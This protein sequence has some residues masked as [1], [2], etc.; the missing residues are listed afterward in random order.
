MGDYTEPQP[1][2]LG[3][4]KYNSLEFESK[5]SP[6]SFPLL[7]D[8]IIKNETANRQ[9]KIALDIGSPGESRKLYDLCEQHNVMLS[10]TFYAVW[11]LV[12]GRYL[13]IENV[14]FIAVKSARNIYSIGVCETD[15][16]DTKTVSQVLKEA[17]ENLKRSFLTYSSVSWPEFKQANAVEGRPTFNSI[18]AVHEADSEMTSVMKTEEHREDEYIGINVNVLPER[19]QADLS[20]PTS[21]LTHAQAENVASTYCQVLLEVTQNLQKK[22]KAINFMSQQHMNQI[23]NWNQKTP[24]VVLD[25]VYN[26]FEARAKASPDSQAIYA[27]DGSLTYR[28]LAETSSR[29]AHHLVNLGVGPE[30]VVPLC[31]EKSKWAI[32]T[33]L[34]VAKAGGAIVNLD[35]KQPMERLTGIVSQVNATMILT[36]QKHKNLWEDQLRVFAV[37]DE[38]ISKLSKSHE[39]SNVKI[40]PTTM[41]YVIFTSGSTGTPKGC[42]IEHSSFLTAA[43]RHAEVSRMDS[44]SRVLQMAPYTFDTSM[45]EIFTTLTTG[46]CICSCGDELAQKGI[47]NVINSMQITWT[48]MTPS[49]VRVLDPAEVP[50]LKTLALGGEALGR[51][52][53][54]TWA[55]KLQLVNGYGPTECSV[56]ATIHGQVSLDSDPAN[57]GRGEGAVCWIVDANDHNRLVPIGAIGELVIQGPIVARGYLNNEAKTTEVFLDEAPTFEKDR[58]SKSQKFRLYKTGDLVR[59]NSDG[60]I[61][62][63]GRKDKQVKLRGQ[64]LELGEIEHHLSADNSVRNALVV[65]PTQGLCSQRLVAVL[66]LHSFQSRSTNDAEVNLVPEEH[67]K[68]SRQLVSGI[69]DRLSK[70]VPAYMIPTAWLVLDSIPLM[71]SGKINGVVMKRWIQGMSEDVYNEVADVAVETHDLASATEMEAALQA[72]WSH[73]LKIPVARVGLNR[74]F[75]GLGGDSITAMRVRSRCQDQNIEVSVQDIIQSKGVSDLAAISVI[76]KL[77]PATESS[78][79]IEVSSSQQTEGLVTGLF[80]K[81][82]LSSIDDVEDVYECSPM[83]EGILLSQV[84]LPGTYAIR[85]VLHVL[86]KHHASTTRER[87]EVAWQRVVDRHPSLR[88]V[89]VEGAADSAE[90]KLFHQVVLKHHTTAIPYVKYGG[91]ENTSDIS[92]FL[93]AQPSPHYKR[94][95]PQHQL[96]ICQS[97]GS[98]TYILVDISH[99]LIDGGSTGIL[100]DDLALAFDGLLASASGPLYSNYIRYLQTQPEIE[101]E[102]FWSTYLSGIQ[103][104]IVPMYNGAGTTVKKI[105]SVKVDFNDAPELLKFSENHGVTIANI[106]QTAWGLVLRLYTGSDDVC[107]GYVASGRDVRIQGIED[108]VGAFI[109]MLVC[110]LT[111]DERVDS[112]DLVKRMQ[113]DYFA[114][115]PHQ[116]CSLAKIQHALNM[117]GMPLFNTILSL[118]RTVSQ[119]PNR[120]SLSF[121]PVEEDDPTDFDIAVSINVGADDLDISLGYWTSLMSDGDAANIAS[122]F[123][124]AI[125]SV[126]QQA[127]HRVANL[128]LFTERDRRQIW[129]W[130]K[131]EVVGI[132]SCVHEYFHEQVLKQPEAQAVCS[133]DG[134]FTYRELD[135][136]S[137]RLAYYLAELGVGPE[138]LVPHCFDKSKWAAVTMMAIMKSG[139]GGVGLSSA[140]PVPRL[141]SIIEGCKANVI[142]VAPQHAELLKGLAEHIVVVDPSFLEH[143]PSIPSGKSLPKASPT[144][145]AFVSFT[146]GSTG[147]PKGIVIE[148][149]S[150]ITSIQ[151][152]GSEWN[153]GPGSRVIQFSA[154]AFDASISDT[155]TTLVRGGTVCIPSD[156]DRLNNLAGA[157]SKMNVNWAFLTPRVLG[158][159]SP[160]TVPQLKTVV[161][162]GEAISREDIAPWTDALDLRIVYGPTEC[163]I[164]S[165]GTEPVTATSDPACLGRAVGTRV[166]VTDPGNSDKLVPVGCI[167][168]L[169]IEG[170]LVTRGYLNDPEKTQVAFFEDPTWVPKGPAEAPRRF[171]KTSDLV[172]YYPDGQLQFIGRRDTQIKIRGQRVE[173]GEIE[174]AIMQNLP[175]VAHVSVDS[176]VFPPHRQT[177]VAFLYMKDSPSQSTPGELALPL[178]LESVGELRDLEKTLTDC[179]PSYMVPSMFVPIS[180]IPLTISGKVDRIQLRAAALHFSPEQLEMFSLTGQEKAAPTTETETKLQAL[181]AQILQKDTSSIGTND[182]FFRLGGDSVGAMKLVTAAR[183]S[184][185]LLA[186]ADIF[187]Y[188]ELSRMAEQV[189]IIDDDNS[190]LVSSQPFGLLNRTIQT[191]ELLQEAAAQCSIETDSIQDIYPCTPLQEGVF[192]LST[193]QPGAYIARTAFHLPNDL[194]ME[195]FQKAWQIL[196]DTHAILRTRIVLFNSVS[197]QVVLDPSAASIQW[198]EKKSSDGLLDSDKGVRIVHGDPLAHYEIVHGEGQSSFIWTAHHAIYDGWTVPLL[199]EQLEGVYHSGYA[200]TE[201]PYSRFIQYLHDSDT[202][203]SDTFWRSQLSGETPASYP[204]LPSAAYQPRP[205]RVW[206]QS[207]NI[208]AKIGSDITMAIILRAAWALVVARY[209]DSNDIVYGLTL[210]GRDAPVKDVQQTLGPTITTVPIKVSLDEQHT[211]EEFLKEI[212]RQSIDMKPYEHTG[213]QNIRRVS[214]EAGPASD[215]KNLFVVQPKSLDSQT[216]LGLEPIPVD[217][218]QFDTYALVIECALGAGTVDIEARYDSGILSD[219]QMETLLHQY[220]HVIQQVNNQSAVTK[221]GDVELLSEQDKKKILQWNAVAPTTDNECVHELITR[222]VTM[223]PDIM[224]VES[225]DGN[226]TYQQLDTLSSRLACYLSTTLGINAESLVPMCFDKSVWTVV[227]MLSVVKAGGACVMLNPEH[228]VTRLAALLEDT[229]SHII[230]SSPEREG[231]FATLPRPTFAISASF[232]QHLP[233]VSVADL[234]LLHVVPSNPAVIIFT[235]GST[236]KPKGI[237][238]QHNSLCTV[239]TQHGDG[240]GFGG[241]GSRVLQFAN[242]TFDVSVGEIFVTLMRGGTI[243]IATEYDRINNLAWVINSMKITWT[244]MT[245]TVA[246][247]LDPK[248]VPNLKTLVLGGEAVSQSLV[249][250]WSKHVTMI[251]SYGPAE[252]TIWTSHALPG[253]TVAPSNIGWG[254]GCRLWIVESSDHNR[255]SPVGC[256]GELL[257]EGPNVARGYMNEPEKTKAAF[258]ENPSWMP[259]DSSKSYRFYKSGDLV[260]YNADGSLTIAGRKDTQVKF[261]GQRIELGEIEFHLRARAE[262]EAGMVTLPKVGLCKAK[263][264]GVVA[265]AEFEPLALE[266]NAVGLIPKDSQRKSQEIVA[267]IQD[268]MSKLLPPYMVPSVWVVLD[269]IPLTASRKINRVPI[270]RWI[271]DVSEETY[272]EIVNATAV[273]EDMPTTAIE[274]Q[275][276]GVWSQILDIP[277]DHIG[278]NR[279]FLS[280][281]GD[282]I[283]AMQVVSRCRTLKVELNVHDVLQSKSLSEVALRATSASKTAISK[284]ESF[285]NAFELSPIQ[286]LY[287]DEIVRPSVPGSKEHHYNQSVLLRLARPV[288]EQDVLTAFQTLVSKNSM[289]RAR[290]IE[291]EEGKWMQ[292]VERGAENSYSL[293]THEF[294][295]RKDI[296]EIIES[297]QTSINIREGP[298]FVIDLFNMAD[299]KQHLSMIAHH[300][301]IDVVSWYVIVQELE[302]LLEGK[303][304]S[305]EPTL[306][307]QTWVKMQAEYAKDLSPKSVL[308]CNVPTADL[309]YWGLN[310]LPVWKDVEEVTF[311][312]DEKITSSLLGVANTALHTEPLDIIISALQHAFVQTFTDRGVPAIFT[313]GHGREPWN[314]SIDLSGTVGWFTTLLPI[315]VPITKDDDTKAVVRVTKDTRRRVSDNGFSYFSCRSFNAEGATAF[316]SHKNIEI[317]LNYLGRNQQLERESALLRQEPLSDGEVINNIGDSLGRLAVFDVSAVITQGCFQM[318]FLFN[319][320]THHQEKIQDWVRRCEQLLKATV[321][322][323]ESSPVEYTLSDFPLISTNY[324]GLSNLFESTLPKIGVLSSD[325][326][327]LY[328]CAPIQEGIILSQAREPGTYEVRQCFEVASRTQSTPID[329]NRLQVAW[330][331]V[332]NRHAALRTIFI[333]TITQNGVYDQLVLR[334][335]T[336]DVKRLKYEGSDV[337]SFIESQLP[338]DYSQPRPHHRL[339]IC[340]AMG[341]VY[342]QLEVSHS[343]TDGTSM[344]LI[345]RDL[346]AAYES[347]LPTGSSALYK[348]YIAYLQQLSEPLSLN[349]W[350]DYLADL[351]PCHF[352]CLTGDS[353]TSKPSLSKSIT[354][355]LDGAS[356]LQRFCEAHEITIGN[357]FQAAWG[358]IL[359]SYTGSDEVCFGYMASGRDIPLKDISDAIGPYI[360]L[361][362]CKLNLEGNN[363]VGQV[364][365][366]LQDDYLNCLPHQH[367]SLAKIQHELENSGES[368]FNT[369][370]SIQRLPTGVPEQEISFEVVDQADPTEYDVD[371]NITIGDKSVEIHMTY[372][373]AYLQEDQAASLIHKFSSVL[374]YISSDFEQPL[375]SLHMFGEYDHD[376]ISKLNCSIPQG[377]EECVHS[378]VEQQVQLRPNAE[379]ISWSNGDSSMTY[380]ELDNQANLLKERLCTLGVGS[381]VVVPLCCDQ[382]SLAIVAMLAVLKA[383]GAYCM[384][385]PQHTSEHLQAVTR[386]LAS[387]VVICSPQY[388]EKFNFADI[389]VI[390]LDHQILEQTRAAVES[391]LV[392]I[393]PGN[394]AIVVLDSESTEKVDKVVIEHRSISTAAVMHGSSVNLGPEARVLQFATYASMSSV[395]EIVFTLCNG[396][397]VCIP[398]H[399]NAGD[400]G[401]TIR[402][403]NV[404]WAVLTSTIA[405][406]VRPIDVPTLKTLAVMGDESIPNVLRVWKDVQLVKIYGHAETSIWASSAQEAGGDK[407]SASDIGRAIASRTWIVESANHKLLAPVGCVGE[408]LIEGPIVSRGYLNNAEKTNQIFLEKPP[409]LGEELRS[410]MKARSERLYKTGKLARYTDNGSISLLEHPNDQSKL[411]GRSVDF[412]KVEDQVQLLISDSHQAAVEIVELKVRRRSQALAVFVFEAGQMTRNSHLDQLL[413]PMTESLETELNKL[414]ADLDKSLPKCSIPTLFIPLRH[415]PL[416]I[417]DN[418]DRMTLRKVGSLLNQDLINQYSLLRTESQKYWSSNEKI[419]RDLWAET[420]RTPASTIAASDSFFALGGDSIGAMRLVNAAR[421]QGLSLTIAAVFQQPTLSKMAKELELLSINDEPLL[422]FS[423]IEHKASTRDIV[424][425]ATNQCGI[426]EDLVEDIYPCT[427]L[428]EGLMAI[429]VRTASAYVIQEVFSIPDTLDVALFQKAWESVVNSSTILRTRIISTPSG[430]YQVVLKQGISWE[431]DESLEQY[432][433][434][435]QDVPIIYGGPLARYAVV[436][437]AS[438]KY[439][440]WT[441]HH[442]IYDGLTLPMIATRVSAIYRDE[443][444]LPEVPYGRFVQYLE[445]GDCDSAAAFWTAQFS[446]PSSAFPQL[447][448]ATYQP[449]ADQLQFRSVSVQRAGSDITLSTVL[450]AAWGV[451]LGVVSE[452]DAVTFGITVSGRNAPIPGVTQIMG[453]TISTVPIRLNV[454]QEQSPLEYL[455]KVQQQAVDMIPF[456]HTGLQN[457]RNFSNEA[458]D[459]TDIRNLLLI[460]P[461]SMPI[462]GSDFLGLT[463]IELEAEE[464]DPY[465]LVVECSISHD[466]VDIKAQYDGGILSMQEVQKMLR[467]FEH[468]I[469]VLNDIKETA[470]S[471]EFGTLE[472][473]DSISPEDLEQ[474]TQWNSRR[475]EA[476]ES[477]VHSLFEE[478]ALLRPDAQAVCSFDGNFTYKQLNQ[479]ADKLA[480]HLVGLGVE[481]ERKVALCFAKSSST[482]I[483]MLAVMKS[484]GVCAMLSPDHPS[485]RIKALVAD[486]EAT[487][488]LCDPASVKLLSKV[489]PSTGIVS[490]DERSLDLLPAIS[491]PVSAT[492]L[493]SNAVFIMHTSGSTGK[494]K[495]II[496]EH[497]SIATGLLAHGKEMGIGPDTRT[498]Q[499]AAYTFDVCLEE[500]VT[501]LM[502][503]GCVCV[504]SESERMNDIAGAMRKFQVTWT[505]LTPTVASLLVPSSIPSLKVLALSGES[506]TKEVVNIWADHVQIINTYGPSECSV[507][508]TCNTATSKLRDPSNIGRGF[509]CT[510]WIVDPNNIDR[511]APVGAIGELLVE[512]PIVARGYL[513]EPEKTAAAFITNPAWAES[514]HGETVRLYRTGD[515]VKYNPDGS[516]KFIGRKDTQVKLHGQRIEMG[517]IEHQIKIA[518]QESSQQVAVEVITPECRGNLKILAAF[519]CA[520]ESSNGDIDN[521]TLPFSK[522]F[523]KR[524]L[525]LQSMLFNA[526][527]KHMVPSL[528]IPVGHM[529]LSTS[530]KLD[531]KTIR[532]VAN[533]FSLQQ[534]A[535]YS[536]VNAEK[537]APSTET[538]KILHKL[539]AQVLHTPD[540]GIEDNFFLLGGDSIGAMKVVAAAS[541]ANISLTVADMLREPTLNKMAQQIDSAARSQV[542]EDVPPEPFALLE[543][544]EVGSLRQEAAKQCGVHQDLIEDIYKC[545]P[546]QEGLMAIT[547][548]EEDAYISQTVYRLPLTIDL[549][550]YQAAW[551]TIAQL[552]SILRT[553]II[554]TSSSQSLQVVVKENLV[555]RS[556]SVLAEYLKTDTL[557]PMSYGQPLMR[558]GLVSG[559]GIDPRL[560]FIYTAHHSVYDG[561]SEATLFEQVETIYKHGVSALSPV[562]PYKNFI[563]YLA[564]IDTQASDAFWNSQLSGGSPSAFPELPSTSY[565]A[566]PNRTQSHPFSVS[567]NNGL[568]FTIPTILKSAWSLLL[569]RYTNSDDV[570]FGHVLSGRTIPLRD[571]GNMVGPTIATVPIRVR[572]DRT[573]TI[574]QFLDGV[575]EQATQ[576]MP[577]EQA[578]LQHI[579]R[580]AP[581]LSANSDFKHLFYIQPSLEANGEDLN[582]ELIPT[583]NYAFDTY[584][585]LVECQISD[586]DVNFS[587]RYDDFV[588][589]TEQV[590]WMLRHLEETV[591]QLSQMPLNLNLDEVDMFGKSDLEQV[592]NWNGPA[593]KPLNTCVHELFRAQ[594]RVSPRATA[595]DAWDG[596]MTYEQL[597]SLASRLSC[598]LTTVGVGAN[599]KVALCFQKSC[600]AIVS[601]LAVM[602]AGGACV[603]LNPDHPVSRLTEI[604]KDV[605]ADHILSAPGH[606]ATLEGL[607]RYL[608]I[609]DATIASRLSTTVNDSLVSVDPRCAA[610]LVFTSGSTGKPKSVVIDHRA[611]C[612][613]IRDHSASLGLNPRS[614]VLQFAAYTF[615][616]SF[617]EIFSTL[618]HGGTVCV[619][620]EHDRM[621][622][623]SSAMNEMEVNWACL[624]PTVASLLRPADVPGLNTLALSGEC[625]TAGNLA[626]WAGKI[627]KLTNI[628]GPSEAS[629]WCS[630]LEELHF[631]TSPANI[632]KAVG[633]RLWVTE[634]NNVNRLAPIGCIGELLVEGPILAQGYLGDPVKTAAAFVEKPT[635]M[636][637]FGIL[638][639]QQRVY[640]TGDLVKYNRNGTLQYLGRN[641]TQIKFHGQRIEPREIEHHIKTH[642]P[643]TEVVVDAVTLNSEEKKTVLVAYFCD[644]DTTTQELDP[645]KIAQQPSKDAQGQFAQLQSALFKQLPAPMVPSL[646]VPLL[647]MPISSAGKLNRLLLSQMVKGLADEQLQ[648]YS[649]ADAEKRAPSTKMEIALVNLW[650][651]ALNIEPKTIGIDDS[652]FRLGGD[653]I[654]AM[655]LVSLARAANIS[656]SIADIFRHPT[657]VDAATVLAVNSPSTPTAVEEPTSALDVQEGDAF[658]EN[659]VSQKIGTDRSNISSVLRTTNFQDLAI[660]GSLT[661]SRWMLNYFYLDGTG[662]VDEERMRLSCLKLVQS[663]DILRTIFVL[664]KGS[665]WQVV[666]RNIEP[667]FIVKETDDITECTEEVY[668]QGKSCDLRLEEPFVQFTLV[669][670]QHGYAHRLIVRIS[671]AQ[672]DG[673]SLPRLWDCLRA[674]YADEKITTSPPFTNYLHKANLKQPKESFNHWRALLDGSS[675]TEFVARQ[676]PDLRSSSDVVTTLTSRIPH[677]PL[678]DHGITFA[679][680]IKSA[681][682]LVLAQ[683]AAR[684]DVVFGHTISGR[685]VDMDEVENIVGPCLNVVPVRVKFQSAWKVIDLLR[686]VQ[687]QQLTNV[688]FESLGFR[689]IIKNCTD[690]PQWSYFS[691]IV[692]HQNIDPDDPVTLGTDS[693]TPGFIGSD[694]DLV[695]ISILSMPVGDNVDV[696]LTASARTI[697]QEDS[698]NLL[699]LL[700]RTITELSSNVLADLSTPSELQ[701]QTPV[702]PVPAGSPLS[703]ASTRSLELLDEKTTLTLQIM[704]ENTWVKVL[705]PTT[706]VRFNSCFFQL[707]GDM[708]GMTQLALLFREQKYEVSLEDLV[709]YSTVDGM[710]QLLSTQHGTANG[711]QFGSSLLAL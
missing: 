177:L 420:L 50:G 82:N 193:T 469:H 404:N 210:S 409:W 519:V 260:R 675:M 165:M 389:E 206:K 556:G 209:A 590:T 14:T 415:L 532:E 324:R 117:S 642:L 60:T 24:E 49:L 648:L 659:V 419:L 427:P 593:V 515:L 237:I 181:F 700:C 190:E 540:I 504:P 528:Y 208:D 299:G 459:A 340:E 308:P 265:L 132:E 207:V 548:R 292:V 592:L 291:P 182:S 322:S 634:R 144:N 9:S 430:S 2:D 472:D 310:R 595:I 64:R 139:G 316:T 344:A 88:T 156:Q 241:V 618:I 23:W 541:K 410:P 706:E 549:E 264:V 407:I 69:R 497:R 379:A 278:A 600:W 174:H 431:S 267:R 272:H 257:I 198:Q 143:L 353:G 687:E 4:K 76:S 484:G 530:G 40:L 467:Q 376:K 129:D 44:S 463:P 522:L 557:L 342:L 660:T 137:D 694:L 435:D 114:A 86:S 391:T 380:L 625:P 56:A 464:F 635:W 160:Q 558:F 42:I 227:V 488:V 80:S 337:V 168:E 443:L 97:A 664:H 361:V 624:T 674:A 446:D 434:R 73:A 235:S 385:N 628:Y 670:Q 67:R 192:I 653:S 355:H 620:S 3:T 125:T 377:L 164:F 457:I 309:S 638:D 413:L 388:R 194:N 284:D 378:L 203:A 30:V 421:S 268:G 231:L 503:G 217:L 269:A 545:S 498:L 304:S 305:T 233:E 698:K 315:H 639:G 502:L 616:I 603:M 580:I 456:E 510:L 150:L 323:L 610:Y 155:F 263:L 134:D 525:T 306:P 596:S 47:A 258:I 357:L 512:G 195:Q 31:F 346:T 709:E 460:Q 29:L 630:C 672:Y 501:T 130:N 18:V 425:Q 647:A 690:W 234:E 676:K 521:L 493:P 482:I 327:D 699:D 621:N 373:D 100:L 95:E 542:T 429:S 63:I 654:V 172:R 128:D 22:L 204:R 683:L 228:P 601:M 205:D 371:F 471:T 611:I 273:V 71:T 250:R 280:L 392:Q 568:A 38:S 92:K 375:A 347:A 483:A 275:L 499:F 271:E 294:S 451:V 300:L 585:L 570:L 253:P 645:T 622:N 189:D 692:Q 374:E 476:V 351:S 418:L 341:K 433:I 15:L 286:R 562:T 79:R 338:V 118:Q 662:S 370:M 516:I 641:D 170:P 594:A 35:A 652:F 606:R 567:R 157:M 243:C 127:T 506:L 261:H 153:V 657:I 350:I 554:H 34:A 366:T 688:P 444:A 422:P 408:L 574:E 121:E 25:T 539:W 518:L 561:W 669:K 115:L 185:L 403:M 223:H 569:S 123:S 58:P 682:A 396:G 526:L 452:S 122:T 154:Y 216:V 229:N 232:I 538:E 277:E 608:L 201:A 262:V 701:S 517:E 598:H 12:L 236:G 238:V 70:H 578:G 147:K 169:I 54:T 448:N 587:V 255:L 673:I 359:R 490:I 283:T 175:D 449:K 21:L 466:K 563:R 480:H 43:A 627:T 615:D 586:N 535:S 27:H 319:R 619:I 303:P 582:L 591:H 186:V 440:I 226:L 458:K 381:E 302:E 96:T 251:D 332:V 437:D 20:Y 524:F 352:P 617:G 454:S 551:Q 426:S 693:Y 333:D 196:V 612:S 254:V 279:S 349:Y 136:V 534:L 411:N 686:Y 697:P 575:Q 140:H 339:T 475:P 384:L 631:D 397:T 104:T 553:R 531:R 514:R 19:F 436:G 685:N 183:E 239:A 26:R 668:H 281:G 48:F 87:L 679:T 393:S 536:L 680:V 329:A 135:D 105:R 163:T 288:R 133:W 667:K 414:K 450:R 416:T 141:Q 573:M 470:S 274:K 124:G 178:T 637:R 10:T 290:F 507:S 65:L 334:Q 550:R 61:N 649:L 77:S 220:E 55:D 710:I 439:F 477:C 287:F 354:I 53:V 331:L 704:V 245:P 41:L 684:S 301:I 230:L 405:N 424:A 599:S 295:E 94:S 399:E 445:N 62:F 108:A 330:Q 326:E 297:R 544:G 116:H 249:D 113:S 398:C 623:L 492:V 486:L 428:Q 184:G 689:E 533:K 244:F 387:K 485:E 247:L 565:E 406:L 386:D 36:S 447:P 508:T 173:L 678:N 527:P 564:N 547:A 523:E 461:A 72:I 142:L 348:D 356:K 658:L 494:P 491:E 176:V 103:P 441:A 98:E 646:F 390:A 84:K 677:I 52:D 589:S 537:Q 602:K 6:C 179:L 707:G 613:S 402:Q 543:D 546:L 221:I 474:I 643:S 438:E 66:S 28:E 655:K 298:L 711:V 552:Q 691:S 325:V 107:F 665:F 650:A 218:T 1:F 7:T 636:E 101:G 487:L 576:M 126:L 555:W 270:S 423:L 696:S 394:S 161:L 640:R 335:Y 383:G 382:T 462:T 57:I 110:R 345:I 614:R 317:C 219:N 112:V 214:N 109:N 212:Q 363:T 99:A 583:E 285:G 188:P 191:E 240:L 468:T 358:L 256:V 8:G 320:N 33:M 158:T 401:K 368:L 119:D 202:D 45:L 509:G 211:V 93:K 224:A 365:K 651:R 166:W 51:I 364:L 479:V 495:G 215:F 312:L 307:F 197:Y 671:H 478:Q 604:I 131:E 343:L 372:A 159:L 318:S 465:P 432:L 187:R 400:V 13:G 626:T 369:I 32:V 520:N 138:I 16:T 91:S 661:Q 242:Y 246:A 225:W 705:P 81:L 632:G 222:Q 500:I 629:I 412:G 282:S 566:R 289:L 336:A 120:T 152:H 481:P 11:A 362:V 417:S 162:G 111:V 513:K 248:E 605:A 68:Q 146:S 314:S 78:P 644:K 39:T 453:P 199:F 59:N 106:L 321:E 597:E 360:N 581:E 703:E 5:L 367:T 584:S 145:A 708:V 559:N 75:I 505:E 266:G 74:S 395:A 102:K 200:P 46:A 252:C 663:F 311:T 633:C 151:A 259:K 577:F 572:L 167:G 328:P 609:V 702:I 313:E 681:W 579:R 455:K 276:A 148:H 213:I 695:D 511:L 529:P 83:Q 89:F 560:H 293:A 571:V 496:L 607:T 85:Q 489:I 473:I 90:H 149:G 588:I 666:L 656:M 442:S 37:D 296:F 180:Y 17:Q 171:Y